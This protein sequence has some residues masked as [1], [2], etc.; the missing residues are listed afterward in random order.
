MMNEEYLRIKAI[1]LV[2]AHYKFNDFDQQA[3]YVAAYFDNQD[4]HK[5]A[6]YIR[7][8]MGVIPTFDIND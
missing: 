2:E 5:L 7:A 1:K 8:L 3:E 6:D 4:D